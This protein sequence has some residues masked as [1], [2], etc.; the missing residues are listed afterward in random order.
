M[1][2][3]GIFTVLAP[4]AQSTGAGL[5]IGLL[6]AGFVAFF[7]ASSSAQLARLYPDSGGTYVY[8]NKR[9]NTF[10]G[11]M[12]G[13]GFIVGKLASCAAIALA[14]GYYV[15]PA[16]AR[17]LAALAIGGFVV[18]N[19]FGIKKTAAVTKVIVSI[20]GVCLLVIILAALHAHP[21]VTNLRPLI[22]SHGW[23]GLLQSAGIWFF[24]F[25]GYSRIAT[26]AEEVIEPKRTIP[27]AIVISLG[28][29]LVVYGLVAITA[30][31]TVGATTLAGTNAP[32][33]AVVKASGLSLTD[34][35]LLGS[36]L[37]TLGSLLSVM[38]G[39]SRTLFAMAGD[40][41]MPTPLA[42]VHPKRQVPYVAE[43]TVGVI[44]I[45]VV[46]L[47]DLRSAIGFSAFTVLLYYSI[48]NA[49]AYTLSAQERL[50]P[51][52]LSVLGLVGCLVLAV[53]L[54]VE[55]VIIGSCVMAV[56]VVVFLGKRR[57]FEM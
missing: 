11:Y 45:I 39:V 1:I 27:K 25:A 51:K 54:P 23:Y 21:S 34:V 40:K 50:F 12:A 31:A 43:I 46:S 20:V 19:Y 41:N 28:I 6:V 42:R 37:A 52:A 49:S 53:T 10:W 29:T 18:L 48:T 2:G 32:L 16:R 17:L 8:G 13:W 38:T 7:N 4:T 30:L 57:T 3:A 5:L 56:G 15:L 44:L 14:F 9:L 26:L 55:S 36:I 33:L 35:V 47:V 22:G 24:A